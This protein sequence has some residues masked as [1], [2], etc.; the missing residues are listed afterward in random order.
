MTEMDSTIIGG[1]KHLGN[2]CLWTACGFL[3][4]TVGAVVRGGEEKGETE[5]EQKEI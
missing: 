1:K 4:D 5:R 3:V 2:L